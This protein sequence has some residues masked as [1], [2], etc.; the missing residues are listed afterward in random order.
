MNRWSRILVLALLAL[1]AGL[2][3]ELMATT[4]TSGICL[5]GGQQTAP[6]IYA[7]DCI[8]LVLGWRIPL[9]IRALCPTLSPL[10]RCR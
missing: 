5:S 4:T 2:D 9:R 3:W 10:C 8:F 7:G 6:Y 1:G